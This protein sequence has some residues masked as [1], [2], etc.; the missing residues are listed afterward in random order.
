MYSDNDPLIPLNE[1]ELIKEKL[2][3]ATIQVPGAGH[4]IHQQ[5][6]PEVLDYILQVYPN[7]KVI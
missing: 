5:S 4:F 6:F 3:P 1:F 2:Q 7:N